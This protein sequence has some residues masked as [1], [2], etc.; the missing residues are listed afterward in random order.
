LYG[1]ALWGDSDVSGLTPYALRRAKQAFARAIELD[2]TLAAT[3]DPYIMV[4][5]GLLSF[6]EGVTVHADELFAQAA[7]KHP[8]CFAAWRMRAA[9]LLRLGH[10]DAALDACRKALRLDTR[11]E[12]VLLVAL[13]ACARQ[14]QSER[15]LELAE[16]IATLRG[17]GASAADVLRDVGL[18]LAD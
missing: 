4:A 15:A 8:G 10:N 17:E 16:R 18:A 3:L 9:T 6:N 5:H 2:P 1:L 7:A 11:N 12:P 14:H 13:V